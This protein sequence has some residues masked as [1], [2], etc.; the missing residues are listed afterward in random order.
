LLLTLSVEIGNTCHD[1]ENALA[2]VHRTAARC[3]HRLSS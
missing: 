3:Q 1:D 2:P